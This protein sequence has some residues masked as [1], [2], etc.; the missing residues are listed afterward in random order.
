MHE[1]AGYREANDFV[2]AAAA[3]SGGV[4][5]PYCRVDPHD[6]AV[7]EAQR[8]LDAGARGIKLHPRAEGFALDQPA[9]RDLV[10]I[11]H[12]RRLPVLIHAGRGIPALGRHSLE[13]ASD[14]TDARLILAHAA[15]SDLAW[16]WREMPA[17]PN[18]LI[19]TSWW[20][21]ADMYALFRLVP[22]GQIVW[23][24]DSPYAPPLQSAVMHLRYAVEAGLGDEALRSVAGDQMR[25]VLEGAELLS[26]PAAGDVEPL[27][28]LLA[29]VVSHL[30]TAVGV[31]VA[32]E[33]P[34]EQ[35]ALARLACAVEDGPEAE[36]YAEVA[37]I[38][39]R[40]ADHFPQPEGM[41]YAAGARMIV[42]AGAIARTPHAPNAIGAP[43]RRPGRDEA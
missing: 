39:D 20:N 3:E 36:L 7:A 9:V 30:V 15:V 42:F 37:A 19:D 6:G 27:D 23:G 16:L 41:R 35:V 14:F 34:A 43:A 31:A 33:D 21:P 11:A 18:L 32:G 5:V 8:A 10:A 2:I 22:P 28:P 26:P 1:P 25:R 17:H 12:E 13:L 24:S 40:V 4:L 29:R 38:L